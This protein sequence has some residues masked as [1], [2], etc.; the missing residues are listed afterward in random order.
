M[1][2]VLVEGPLLMTGVL[3]TVVQ[4]EKRE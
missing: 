4:T 3:A 2:A 1:V